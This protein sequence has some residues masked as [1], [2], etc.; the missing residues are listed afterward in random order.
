MRRR[1]TS[2]MPASSHPSTIATASSTTRSRVC[3]SV[4]SS[5]SARGASATRPATVASSAIRSTT[6]TSVSGAP[7]PPGVGSALVPRSVL[8]GALLVSAASLR[9]GEPGHV[10]PEAPPGRHRG[11]AG[12]AAVSPAQGVAAGDPLTGAVALATVP[13]PDGR[14]RP[15]SDPPGRDA[16]LGRTVR[17]SPGEEVPVRTRACLP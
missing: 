14:G 7:D 2:E 12:A 5:A 6:G 15:P 3:C 17:G 16:A 13:P 8:M 9:R 10:V 4:G 1:V 11:G